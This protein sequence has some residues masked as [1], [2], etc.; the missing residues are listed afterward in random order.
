MSI[1]DEKFYN[2]VGQDRISSR[3]GFRGGSELLATRLPKSA[4]CGQSNLASAASRNG[5]LRSY[6]VHW[7]KF[8]S[9]RA[10]EHSGSQA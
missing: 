8:R 3:H 2:R 5:G 6:N 10:T 4:C 7:G 9:R 1:G